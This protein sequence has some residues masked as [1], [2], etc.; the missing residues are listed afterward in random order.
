M[1]TY[2]ICGS[3]RFEK[4]MQQ[5]AYYLETQ[6]G[7]NI[8]QCVYTSGSA[9]PTQ[10]DLQKLQAAHYAKI[11]LSDGIYVL[12]IGGYIGSAVRDEIEYAKAHGKEVIY[13]CG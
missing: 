6:K 8:L 2:T 12:N 13:H 3:M 4:E 10:E 9:T 1:K 11:D 5:A 7:C